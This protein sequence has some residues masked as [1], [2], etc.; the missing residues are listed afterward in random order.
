VTAWAE[1]G[2][3]ERLARFYADDLF[4]GAGGW[5]LAADQ[6]GIHARG[7]ENMPEARD[8]RDAAGLTTIHDDV[9]T[10]EPDGSASGLIASPPCQ[11]FSQAGKGAGRKALDHVLEAIETGFYKDLRHLRMFGQA[12]GEDRTALVLTPLH[13]ATQHPA[14]TWATWEQVPTVLPVWEACAEVMRT[15]GWNVWTGTLN[16][17]Q[18]GVPQTRRRAFL[19]ASR[20]HAVTPPAPTHSR[21]YSRTP[22]RLDPGVA[23]WISMAEALGWGLFERPSPTVTAGDTESGGAEPIAHL[24]R[25]SERSDWNPRECD[26]DVTLTATNPRPHGAHRTPC[27]PAPTLAFGKE[28]PRWNPRE[29]TPDGLPRFAQQSDNR[30]AT[31]VAGRDLVQAP[32]ATANRF[33]GSTKSRNDGVRVTVEEAGVLQSFPADY[34][35]QGGSSK[36]F[37]QCGNAVPVGL[38]RAALS[39]LLD[40]PVL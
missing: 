33:N 17:E 8:T 25:Y 11:T 9:W 3:E 29:T 19:L 12:V 34:P 21:Y 30:P 18:Y 35:W 2:A 13:F 15:Y 27:Q 31:V 16:A 28:R 14:Y 6:L 40:G 7:V 20:D 1:E 4:A 26:C 39:V 37:L 32:G 36:Q 10:Y 5:D 23:K 24:S 22:S 38:A